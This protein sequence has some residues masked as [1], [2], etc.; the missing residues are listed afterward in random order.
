VE[1]SAEASARDWDERPRSDGSDNPNWQ[2][3]AVQPAEIEFWQAIHDR[4]HIRHRFGP[5]GVIPR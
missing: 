1:L 2:L 5:D 3:Y 4:P